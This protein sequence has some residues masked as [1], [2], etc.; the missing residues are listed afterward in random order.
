MVL[1]DW[2]RIPPVAA[3]LLWDAATFA[4]VKFERSALALGLV[5]CGL[6]LPGYLVYRGY[7]QWLLVS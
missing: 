3:N 6:M 1:A 2:V 7:G 5:P 4:A